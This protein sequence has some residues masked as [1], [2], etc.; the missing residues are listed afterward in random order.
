MNFDL[1]ALHGGTLVYNVQTSTTAPH[2]DMT[3]LI[4]N[5][6]IVES[7]FGDMIGYERRELVLQSGK[8][9]VG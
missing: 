2:D 9:Q 7:M 4:N 5:N 6:E 1:Y 8:V 3:I